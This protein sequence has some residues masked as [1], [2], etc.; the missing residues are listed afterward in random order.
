MG[1]AVLEK[2]PLAQP[3]AVLLVHH[4]Q[5]Q[6]LELHVL[7]DEGVGTHQDVQLPRGSGPQYLPPSRGR[8]AAREQLHAHLQFFGQ[9]L[10]E[11]AEMLFG[12]DLRGSHEHAL[13]TALPGEQK[14]Q[15]GHHRL[16]RAHLPLQEAV[17]GSGAHHVPGDLFESPPLRGGEVEGQGFQEAAYQGSGRGV[18]YPPGLLAQ[19]TAVESQGH[20]HE[21]E[22]LVGHA[23]AGAVQ[24]PLRTG[25]MYLPQGLGTVGVGVAAP[26]L[27]G[28]RVGKVAVLV[29][30][31]H[32][33]A[34]QHGRT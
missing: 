34:P 29:Q 28:H 20:L 2:Y 10:G 11:V 17:H 33:Q 9:K 21:Q 16:P 7:L 30:G 19:V 3:E 25:K 31:A 18:G 22:L 23:L 27:V 13:V 6:V 8:G 14:G 12:Q 4:H 15:E 5:A 26:Q 24:P 1:V 32:D